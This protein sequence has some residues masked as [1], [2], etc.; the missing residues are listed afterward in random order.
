L[1]TDFAALAVFAPAERTDARGHIE[2]PVKLPDNL[3]RYRVMAVAVAHENEFGSAESTLTARL[4]LMVRPSAPRFLNFGDT[5]EFPVV[6]QNQTDTPLR[7]SLA[8]R[9]QNARILDSPGKR[10]DIGRKDRVE[11]RFQAAAGQPG[12]ARFQI[13]AAAGDLADASNVELPVWTP[14]TTEAFAT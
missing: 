4:P 5:F 10:V 11:V 7:A 8:I 2:V 3:T 13:A 6:L 12:K 1:R 9:S 14:A